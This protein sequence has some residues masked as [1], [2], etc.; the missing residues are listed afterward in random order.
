MPKL[1]AAAAA[2][3]E[4]AARL[5]ADRGIQAMDL[6]HRT[7]EPQTLL[8]LMA[9]DVV[10]WYPAGKW[11]GLTIGKAQVAAMLE[12]LASQPATEI[13]EISCVTQKGGTVAYRTAIGLV[14]GEA[15]TRIA[16]SID[17]VEGR[18]AGVREYVGDANQLYLERHGARFE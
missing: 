12:D 17:I 2:E 3:G 1:A 18:I 5:I 15:L 7:G 16:W 4:R 8:A 6:F 14:G 11:R 9:E 10:F 13:R